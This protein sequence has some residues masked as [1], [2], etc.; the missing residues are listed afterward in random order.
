MKRF[1]VGKLRM[2]SLSQRRHK[3][4]IEEIAVGLDAS[5]PEPPGPEVARL[6]RCAERIRQA[7]ASGKPVIL[8]F[9]AHFIKNGLGPLAAKLVETG[10]IS[11]LATNGAGCIHD[12]EFAF[13]GQSTE[14]VRANTAEG[15]FGTWDETGRYTHLAIAVGGTHG[16][17]YG[18]SMGKLIHDEHL[19]VPEPDRLRERIAAHL[20]PVAHDI[21]PAPYQRTEAAAADADLLALIERWHVEPGRL[22]LPHPW[23]C[24]SLQW[25][26]YRCGVPFTVPPGI[27]DAI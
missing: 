21:L 11:H 24:F 7:R 4:R 9:G 18:E 5:V 1:D 15:R 13:I 12:W 6:D 3:L 23:R 16:L 2:Y 17:G 10:W 26:A 22:V 14:D 20:A 8:T 27:G 25:T 19:D